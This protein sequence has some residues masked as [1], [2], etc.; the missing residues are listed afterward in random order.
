MDTVV[1]TDSTAIEYFTN[2]V[3]LA[4]VNAEVDTVLADLH[5]ISGYPTAVLLDTDRNEIDRIADIYEAE[6]YVAK[7]ND[8][9]NGIGTLGNLLERAETETDRELYAEIANKFSVRRG[10]DEA[11]NWHAKV[12]EAGSAT[13]SLSGVSRG[14]LARLDYR[15][16]NYDNALT[17]YKSLI[18]DFGGSN[19]AE[20]AEVWTAIILTK[21]GDTAAA[22]EAYEGFLQHWPESEDT[23]Y[24]NKQIAKLKGEE[25]TE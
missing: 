15:E 8:Y 4:K 24:A 18:D 19:L 9:L 5:K 10:Y 12:I 13:D 16:K 14:A 20:N 21:Q 23:S 6:P 11:R 2:T 25:P 1:F 3:I 7:L 22:I 17:G